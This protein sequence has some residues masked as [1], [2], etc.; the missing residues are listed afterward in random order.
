M[1][2]K[3]KRDIP[4]I[5]LK[6]QYY[7]IK[8]EIDQAIQNVTKDNAFING[9]YVKEFEENFA[10]M[11]GVNYCL[12]VGNGTDALFIALKSLGVGSGDEVITAANSFI[13]TSTST[14]SSHSLK[15]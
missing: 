12:G 2:W 1:D 3:N 14:Y 10:K 6:A 11:I 7:L 4:L 13:A 9:K 8:D 15:S 5:D